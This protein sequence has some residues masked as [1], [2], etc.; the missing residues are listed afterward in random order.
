MRTGDESAGG[1]GILIVDIDNKNG[2]FVSW[3]ILREEN[4]ETIETVTVG[5][6]NGG[7]HLWFLYPDGYSISS[8]QDALGAGIDVRANT[9][10]ALIPPSITAQAYKFEINPNDAPIAELPHW[11]LDALNARKQEKS[12]PKMP[13]A[14]KVGEIVNQGNRHQSLVEI[15]GAMRRI[16]FDKDNYRKH[17]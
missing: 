3:D 13:A 15:A 4:P 7:E 12:K 1:A 16:G 8:S 2:G 11:I 9:G 6:G 10:Y 14:A 17:R 5:T